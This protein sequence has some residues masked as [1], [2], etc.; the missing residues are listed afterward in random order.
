MLTSRQS[1]L[2]RNSGCGNSVNIMECISGVRYRR[3]IKFNNEFRELSLSNGMSTSKYTLDGNKLIYVQKGK[4][5][6]KILREFYLTH[7]VMTVECDKV[8]CR[9]YLKAVNRGTVSFG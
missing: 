6:I 4:K 1:F 8:S 3:T 7:M 2:I 9:K 5:E